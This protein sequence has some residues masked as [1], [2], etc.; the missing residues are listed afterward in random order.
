LQSTGKRP[1]V[2]DSQETAAKRPRNIQPPE[3]PTRLTKGARK[4]RPAGARPEV[5][6]IQHILC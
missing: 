4:R 6:V 1:S 2:E 3:T 5:M